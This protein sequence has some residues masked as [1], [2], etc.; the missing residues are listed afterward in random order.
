L[1][2]S[3]ITATLSTSVILRKPTPRLHN[4]KTNWDTYRQIKQDK[5]NLSTKPKEHKDITLETNHLLNSL[6]HA[7]KEAT[8]NSDPQRTTNNIPY[9]I[10]KL[11]AEKRRARSIWQRTYAPDKRRKYNRTS[12]KLKSKLPEMWNE[13]F[14]KYVS[15]FK[16]QDNS[17]WKPIKNKG[18]SKTT[19]SPIRKYSTPP[20]PWA[21]SD[22]GKLLAEHLSE[23]FSPH[24]NDQDQEVEQDLATPN[25][26]QDR[27]KAFT[28]KEIK[29]DIKML[30]Q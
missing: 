26:S 27:L 13:S 10:K 4:S 12:S 25:E 7:T 8:P 29:D 30:N 22:R 24:N 5:V 16:R 20:G 15:N 6:Q 28:L 21:K 3:P 17:I 19:S 2:H 18:I 9:E 1:D 14:E 11:V 23:V